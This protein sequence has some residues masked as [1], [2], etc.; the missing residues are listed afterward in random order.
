MRLP[1]SWSTTQPLGA[2]V[3]GCHGVAVSAALRTDEVAVGAE[4]GGG[5][6]VARRVRLPASRLPALAVTTTPPA[7]H[8]GSVVAAEA[9]LSQEAR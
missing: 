1:R 7:A 6:R 8:M 3:P 2:A 4:P 9:R 5:A